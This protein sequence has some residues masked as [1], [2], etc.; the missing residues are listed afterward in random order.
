MTD[1]ASLEDGTTSVR[2]EQNSADLRAAIAFHHSCQKLSS[3]WECFH[4]GRA[5]LE[6]QQCMLTRMKIGSV[7]F[8]CSKYMLFGSFWLQKGALG[9]ILMSLYF[10]V[11]LS[12]STVLSTN[13]TCNVEC[14]KCIPHWNMFK[15]IKLC[16]NLLFSLT[17][18]KTGHI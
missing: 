2:T 9:S 12:D 1:L 11:R 5:Q 3:K 10:G 14:W 15:F 17:W 8:E 13:V 6:V 7:A 18:H 16:C 4:R